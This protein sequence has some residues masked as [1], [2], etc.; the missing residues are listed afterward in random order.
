MTSGVDKVV[1]MGCDQRATLVPARRGGERRGAQRSSSA[2]RNARLHDLTVEWDA[3]F[4]PP[5]QLEN[6]F[7]CR[8]FH[9]LRVRRTRTRRKD[10]EAMW[11]TRGML[12]R[13]ADAG[14]ARL[15]ASGV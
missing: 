5:S 13:G 11:E 9:L 7:T 2:K 12:G 3:R 6:S 1:P 15:A 10:Q 8:A 4:S 14:A